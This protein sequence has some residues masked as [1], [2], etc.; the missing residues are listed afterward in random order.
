MLKSCS[1]GQRL[2][3]DGNVMVVSP[4]HQGLF[5]SF[6]SFRFLSSPSGSW[7]T[8]LSS[9]RGICRFHASAAP[10][11]SS[12]VRLGLGRRHGYV[13]E[14]RNVFMGR[15]L[16]CPSDCRRDV[17]GTSSSLR[18][19]GTDSLYGTTTLLPVRRPRLSF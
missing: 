3:R 19:G 16:Y 7:I 8:F 9:S 17:A 6:F 10:S 13:L 12:F 1:E 2:K 4:A 18:F 11:G 5:F 14:G 15:R